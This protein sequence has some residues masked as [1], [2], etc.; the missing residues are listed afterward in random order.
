MQYG[1]PIFAHSNMWVMKKVYVGLLAAIL[2]YSAN[3]QTV[4]YNRVN[5]T[6]NLSP[7]KLSAVVGGDNLLPQFGGTLEG[8]VANRFYYNLLYRRDMIRPWLIKENDILTTNPER[9]GNHFEGGIE[10][11]LKRK[12]S[13]DGTQIKIITSQQRYEDVISTKYFYADVDERRMFSLRA[14][15]YL[16]N[17]DFFARDKNKRFLVAKND[18]LTPPT[19]GA[20]L[21]STNNTGVYAGL[22][23]RILHKARIKALGYTTYHYSSVKYYADFMYGQTSTDLTELNGAVYDPEET[24]KSPWGWRAGV[25]TET[26]GLLTS[27]EFGM[28]PTV[29]NRY[30]Y[31]NYFLLTFSFNLIGGDGRYKMRD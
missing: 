22:A 1:R 20:Y 17:R 8:V 16:N 23:W 11:Y 14:G 7:F 6:E 31:F 10:I 24:P 21:A 27:L 12:I 25:Q 19:G 29:L 15:A 18:T 5:K 4:S 28:R 26:N 30:Q 3:A 9:L 13:Y 2:A